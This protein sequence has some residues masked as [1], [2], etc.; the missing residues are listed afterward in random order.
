MLDFFAG[1]VYANAFEWCAHKFL[2]HDEGKKKDSFWRFHWAE[3]HKVVRQNN[4][5]DHN[6]DASLLEWNPQ[7]K[8]VAALI[9]AA[10]LHSP[11]FLVAPGFGLATLL[12]AANYYYVHKKSHQDPEWAREHLPWHYDHHMGP[13]QDANFC[14][15]FPLF[16]YIMGTREPYVGTEK[17]LADKKRREEILANKAAVAAA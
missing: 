9:G 11:V 12:S 16:D 13:N 7:S 5:Y 3:H 14:V 8:E 2:L 1:L 17:E 4:F 10:V 15:T 6:Y